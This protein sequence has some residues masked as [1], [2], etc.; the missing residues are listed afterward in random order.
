MVPGLKKPSCQYLII[1]ANIKLNFIPFK[2]LAYCHWPSI[3][4]YCRLAY[5]H[6]LKFYENWHK[7]EKLTTELAYIHCPGRQLISG[8]IR[9]AYSHCLT[10]SQE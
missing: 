6:C 1:L 4:E 3:S 7:Q 2:T 10:Y 8:I 9:L 5:C